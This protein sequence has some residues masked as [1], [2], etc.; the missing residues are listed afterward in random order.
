MRK[1]TLL[2]CLMAIFFTSII[3]AQNKPNNKDEIK[4]AIDCTA[5]CDMSYIKTEIN[6]VDFV[7]DRLLSNI[8][9]MIT[10]QSTGSGGEELK[11][12]FSG[13]ENF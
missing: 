4:V 13:R 1:Q 5:W 8:Y 10:S 12:F 3:N 11:L 6:Y 9:I 2:I 7:P